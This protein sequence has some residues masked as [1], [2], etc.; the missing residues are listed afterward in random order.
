MNK[1]LFSVLLIIHFIKYDNCSLFS[2]SFTRHVVVNTNL[3]H[4]ISNFAQSSPNT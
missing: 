1:N 4:Q 3:I 2:S